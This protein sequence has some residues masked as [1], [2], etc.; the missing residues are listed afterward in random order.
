MNDSNRT[1]WRR[2]LGENGDRCARVASEFRRHSFIASCG[3]D[4][5]ASAI[6]SGWL[7][8]GQAFAAPLPGCPANG[9]EGLRNTSASG[10]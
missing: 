3:C 9:L 10:R 1:P 4:D 7:I 2:L 8:A 5:L 6:I